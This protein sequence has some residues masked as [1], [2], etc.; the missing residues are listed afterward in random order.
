MSTSLLPAQAPEERPEQREHWSKWTWAVAVALLVVGLGV[1]YLLA[2]SATLNTGIAI[3]GVYVLV[4][5][6]VLAALGALSVRHRAGTP[7]TTAALFVVALLTTPLFMVSGAMGVADRAQAALA[8]IFGEEDTATVLP[9]D[10]GLLDEED[11]GLGGNNEPLAT[12]EPTEDLPEAQQAAFEFFTAAA[13]SSPVTELAAPGSPAA[14]YALFRD[15]AS[16]AE[17]GTGLV[18]AVTVEGESVRFT[19]EDGTTTDYTDFSVTDGLISD[20]VREGVPIGDLLHQD[21]GSAEL[22]GGGVIDYQHMF[23]VDSGVQIAGEMEAGD[24]PVS[25]GSAVYVGPDKAQI[26]GEWTAAFETSP[27]ARTPFT[28]FIPGGQSGG[29]LTADAYDVEN[30]DSVETV[31]SIP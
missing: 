4:M 25:Y 3:L 7:T 20:F 10:E 31:I 2:R 19:Y 22:G 23:I 1:V 28:I 26:D 16:A 14:E 11:L 6:G 21:L 18:P 13:E 29:N 9:E 5:A 8:D 12:E 15:V 27:G 24:V 30:F 17:D